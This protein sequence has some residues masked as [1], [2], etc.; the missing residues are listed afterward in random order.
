M[1]STLNDHREPAV[2]CKERGWIPGTMLVGDEGY[3]PTVIEITGIGKHKML[4]ETI[5]HNG[6]KSST[7]E[8]S[9]V[10]WCRDWQV[11]PNVEVQGPGAAS[12]RTVPCNDGL[13]G[14]PTEETK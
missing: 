1:K 3:G 4:A 5:S 2:I 9:W 13:A 14:A 12:L 10:L 8:A 7:G 6:E 11:V